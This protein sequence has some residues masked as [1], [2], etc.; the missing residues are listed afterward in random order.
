[1]LLIDGD[2]ICYRTV[3]S[4]EAESL[5]DMKRIADGY[6]TNMVS[7]VDPEIKDYTVFISG[8]ENYR[9]DIAVTKE[10]KGNRTAEKPEHLDDIRA[11]L[12]SSHPSDL[13]KGEEA[14]DR[15]AIEATARGNT[16]II[17]SIDKD[18]DQVPGWHYNFVKRIRYYVTQKEAI[19]NF[20]CQIL[21]GDRIDNIEGVYGIG[22][23]KALKALAE[24]DTEA[25]MYAK[26]VELLGSPERALENA[27][28]L[29]LRRTPNQLWQPPVEPV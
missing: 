6:I 1:M 19:L 15:I 12:L 5:D 14:D 7:E 25:K 17:C 20:Y 24:L 3:F 9:K 27:R 21:V 26:C 13:S 18:F 22:P 29:W 4:K 8:K 10:Y 28:L 23:K 2:I 11:H 16:A